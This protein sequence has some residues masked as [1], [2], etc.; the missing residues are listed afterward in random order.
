MLFTKET[1]IKVNYSTFDNNQQLYTK[2]KADPNIDY[3][4][5]VPS[6]YIVGRM[7]REGM[8]KKLDKSKLPNLKYIKPKLL[9]RSYDP[10]NF[11]SVPYLW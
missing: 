4:V 5:A 3:D 8:L 9:N 6:S 11:Y 2:L 7:A 1:G 10:G